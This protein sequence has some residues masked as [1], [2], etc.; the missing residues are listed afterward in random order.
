MNASAEA[1]TGADFI[2]MALARVGGIFGKLATWEA[3]FRTTF[4]VGD[5]ASKPEENP[6]TMALTR[7][8][9]R[10]LMAPA[11]ATETTLE[12]PSEAPFA[13]IAE[14][15]SVPERPRHPKSGQRVLPP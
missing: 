8:T 2:T 13:T 7:V 5:K 14:V 10:E 3:G 9:A 4:V 1:T 15:V 6:I 11:P 12:A